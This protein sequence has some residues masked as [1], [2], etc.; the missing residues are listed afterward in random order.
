MAEQ[1]DIGVMA[2][3]VTFVLLTRDKGGDHGR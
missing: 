2:L 1:Q 3:E